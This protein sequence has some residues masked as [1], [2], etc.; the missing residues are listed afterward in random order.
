MKICFRASTDNEV[1]PL[2]RKWSTEPRKINS[3]NFPVSAQVSA[4]SNRRK[5][6]HAKNEDVFT[7]LQNPLA[8]HKKVLH[9]QLSLGFIE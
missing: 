8:L 6:T 1:N 2:Q 9:V 5:F 7:A 3:K 4:A